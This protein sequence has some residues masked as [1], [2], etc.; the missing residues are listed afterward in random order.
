MCWSATADLVVGTAIASV[1]A[2]CVARTRR[3]G[4]LPLAA[5]PLLLGAHQLVEAQIWHTGG[6]T[7]AATVAWAVIALPLLAVWVPVGVWCAV[8]RRTGRRVTAVV[9]V[10]VVTAAFLAHALA[11]RPVRAEI[12]GHTMAYVIGLPDA[13]LLVAGYLIATVGAL[14]LSGDRRLTALGILT[15]AG[16]L[17]CWLLWRL[18]FVSTWCALAAISSVVLY[19]WVRTRPAPRPVL[20]AW[21]A[22]H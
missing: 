21:D 10:G 12:R 22:R 4:D 9:A 13:E 19:G 6:G 5:L 3:A 18:E 8:P 15:G 14:L 2:V 20:P 11:T 17:V 1:G 16:A 7:G